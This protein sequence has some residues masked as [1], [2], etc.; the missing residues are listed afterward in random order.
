MSEWI[1]LS[2]DCEVAEGSMIAVTVADRRLILYRTRAGYFVSDRRCTHQGADLLR[3][4]LDGEVIECPV[5]QGRFNVV[6]GKAL[7]APASSPLKT[8]PV[9]VDESGIY[10][11]LPEPA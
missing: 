10:V 9:K 6:T 11:Q 2:L 8:Y 5:H 7:N 3:G 1:R 4:Y